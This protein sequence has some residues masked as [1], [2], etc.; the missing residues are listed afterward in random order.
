MNSNGLAKNY[1]SLTP[2]ERLP[3]VLAA[4]WLGDEQERAG[5]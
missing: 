2:E 5:C 4:S 1:G 3:L